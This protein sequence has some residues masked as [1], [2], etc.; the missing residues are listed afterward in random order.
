MEK[1]WEGEEGVLERER[2]SERGWRD[3]GKEMTGIRGLSFSLSVFSFL[4]SFLLYKCVPIRRETYVH[5]FKERRSIYL[6][7]AVMRSL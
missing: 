7:M 3:Q 4:F 1:E 6:A 2:E 5:I